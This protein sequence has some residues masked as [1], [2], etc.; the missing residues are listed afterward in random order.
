M[1]VAVEK[2]RQE[3]LFLAGIST[4]HC[5]NS[6]TLLNREMGLVKSKVMRL[7]KRLNK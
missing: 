5:T 2:A 6:L 4:H 1:A 3:V 7:L